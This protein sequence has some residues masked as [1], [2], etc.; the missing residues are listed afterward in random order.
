LRFDAFMRSP[1]AP[2]LCGR[3]GQAVR[4]LCSGPGAEPPAGEDS[5]STASPQERDGAH[6]GTRPTVGTCP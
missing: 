1:S 4:S 2:A 3:P 6:P 5:G